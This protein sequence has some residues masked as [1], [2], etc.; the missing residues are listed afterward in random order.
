MQPSPSPER[1]SSPS[2][3]DAGPAG[4]RILELPSDKPLPAVVNPADTDIAGMKIL[5]VDDD[6]RNL[7]ALS[8]ILGRVGLGVISAEGG[9]EGVALLEQTRDVDLV[10][11]DMMMPGMDGYA[12][13]SAM[14]ELPSC[15]AIPLIAVTAMVG[16]GE[17]Q[18]CIDA[19]ASGYISKPVDTALLLHI[20]GEWLPAAR[21]T[22]R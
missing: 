11:V 15:E 4:P 2:N 7:F 3:G 16:P 17:G 9:E 19:G 22:A 10:L 12:T 8:A 14:R 21:P 13:M 20:L 1:S 6:S 18:R 5:V